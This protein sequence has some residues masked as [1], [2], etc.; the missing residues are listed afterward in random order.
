MQ[1]CQP[2]SGMPREGGSERDRPMHL[3]EGEQFRLQQLAQTLRRSAQLPA[4]L[5]A[6]AGPWH[7]E[8]LP[9]AHAQ[10]TCPLPPRAPP[11]LLPPPPGRPGLRGAIAAAAAAPPWRLLPLARGVPQ[12][13]QGGPQGQGLSAPCQCCCLNAAAPRHPHA[14]RLV[15]TLDGRGEAAG[16][17]SYGREGAPP[18]GCTDGL[19][20]L[21]LGFG[22]RTPARWVLLNGNALLRLDGPSHA[23]PL[24]PA[25][26]ALHDT[27]AVSRI[28]PTFDQAPPSGQPG[29]ELCRRLPLFAPCSC[30]RAAPYA[31]HAAPSGLLLGAPR[32]GPWPPAAPC[33]R[34]RQAVGVQAPDR[35][36]LMQGCIQVT[37]GCRYQAAEQSGNASVLPMHWSHPVG[38]L[39][40]RNTAQQRPHAQH[41][42]SARPNL[43]LSPRS[44]TQ[45]VLCAAARTAAA[46]RTGGAAGGGRAGC[47]C[48]PGAEQPAAGGAGSGR[49][50]SH[51]GGCGGG[52]G[53]AERGRDRPGLG[54]DRQPPCEWLRPVLAGA[55]PSDAGSHSPPYPDLQAASCLHLAH[56]PLPG[57]KPGSSHLPAAHVHRPWRTFWSS[58]VSRPSCLP[59][60]TPHAALLRHLQCV[61]QPGG[62]QGQGALRCASAAM[63]HAAPV[64]P[65]WAWCSAI[66]VPGCIAVPNPPNVC[67][68]LFVHQSCSLAM[69]SSSLRR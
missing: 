7:R 6:A 10:S 66:G 33:R 38:M 49:G 60:H 57:H 40:W 47:L 51:R 54:P 15:P 29:C 27:R 44:L 21:S 34:R 52:R 12:G 3:M 61:S 68:C 67:W 8:Q 32:S 11:P 35:A 2:A 37:Q 5:T 48:R 58:R 59:K 36:A 56:V 45:Q 63:R 53:W 1:V 41:M 43:R 14:L 4:T 24:V 46:A 20:S 18:E 64:L 25:S 28:V 62:P 9:P 16:L 69:L 42:A 39:R 22:D 65:C 17:H 30:R 50:G 13:L 55:C 23:N 19:R 31:R 26:T